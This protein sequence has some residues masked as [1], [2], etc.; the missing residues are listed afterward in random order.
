MVKLTSNS[1]SAKRF[2]PRYGR[3]NKE[4]FSKIEN[5]QRKL[6]KCPYCSYTQVKRVAVGIWQCRKCNARFTGGAY[7]IEKKTF[8]EEE[9]PA[10]E[11]GEQ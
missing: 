4:K 3:T 2:G 9:T 7:S 11:T 6:H 5:E 1:L 8:E 10:A